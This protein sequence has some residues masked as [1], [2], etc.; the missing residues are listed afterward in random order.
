MP[1]DTPVALRE[2]R[3]REEAL[4]GVLVYT[5]D[6]AAL[7]PDPA[8]KVYIW[9]LGPV[10]HEVPKG[11]LGVFVIPACGDDGELGAPLVLP[12]VVRDSYLSNRK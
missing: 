10:R 4:N 11:S 9:N 3:E 2:K 5:P 7:T 1:H 12:S 8:Y 6:N